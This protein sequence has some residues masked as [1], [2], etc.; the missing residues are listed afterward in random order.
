M[1][2]KGEL[3][4]R[5]FALTVAGLVLAVTGTL[6]GAG[7]VQAATA[8][9]QVTHLSGVLTARRADG[10]LKL[11]SVRSEVAEGDTLI[12]EQDSYARIKF[13]DDSEIV[14]R[15]NSQL[16][17]A[18]YSF[19]RDKPESGNVILNMLRG[20]LRSVSGLIGKYNHTAV[21]IHTPTATI[22][23]RGTNFGALMCD[24]DCA[25]IPTVTGKPPENGL[26]VDVI[27]GAIAVKNQAG[28]QVIN[29]GQFGFVRSAT[30]LPAIVPPQQGIPVTMPLSIARNS[31][32]GRD[33]IGKAKKSECTVE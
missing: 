16:K 32:S 14:M 3:T 2:L 11:F 9:G 7:L 15:P 13:S 33:G 1:Q 4:M 25:S 21:L 30:T 27:E 29:T 24:N 23:I 22:G 20:G 31:S 5:R 12:T 10:S 8:A 28:E 17:V 6:S 26:H 18:T 19:N